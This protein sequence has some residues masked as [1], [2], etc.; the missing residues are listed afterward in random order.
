[1]KTHYAVG[2]TLAE[3]RAMK[4]QDR[5]KRKLNKAFKRMTKKERRALFLWLDGSTEAHH[6]LMEMLATLMPNSYEDN[7]REKDKQ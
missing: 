2:F 4:A 3:V 1:M 7:Q 5:A 6:E